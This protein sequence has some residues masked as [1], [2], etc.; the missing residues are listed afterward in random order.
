MPESVQLPTNLSQAAESSFEIVLASYLE[1]TEKGLA[2][3]I[4]TW[5]NRYPQWSKELRA[6]FD[7]AAT[8]QTVTQHLPSHQ[9]PQVGHQL[10]PYQLLEVI[11]QGGMGI[12]WKARHMRLDRI[13][14][15]KLLG[16]QTGWQQRDWQRFQNE[17]QAVSSLD[18]PHIVPVFDYGEYQGQQ[19]LAMKLVTG[20]TLSDAAI[21]SNSADESNRG[22]QTDPVVRHRRIARI[23]YQVAQAIH[24][25][26]QRGVLHRDLKPTN[27][28]ID[29]QDCPF[30]V[31]F[32]LAKQL[33]AAMNLT[34]T[35]T[36]LGTPSYMAPEAVL[37]TIESEVD[38]PEIAIS[39]A[40]GQGGLRTN[41]TTYTTAVDV[42]GL[43]ATLYFLLTGQAPVRSRTFAAALI[44]IRDEEP[45]SVRV[46][47]PSVDRNLAAIC[48]HALAKQPVARYESADRLAQDLLNW[49]EGRSITAREA[50]LLARAWLWSK[51]NKVWATALSLA[52][53]GLIFGMGALVWGLRATTVARDEALRQHEQALK[54]LLT[55]WEDI[56]DLENLRPDL[57]D[58]RLE[59]L[60]RIQTQLSPM[61]NDP[62]QGTRASETNF[63]LEADM[64]DLCEYGVDSQRSQQ[65]FERAM[66]IAQQLQQQSGGKHWREVSFAM[67]HLA[68]GAAM[69]GKL[70]VACNYLQECLV[71]RAERLGREPSLQ[72][73]ADLAQTHLRL[74]WYLFRRFDIENSPDFAREGAR[75]AAIA[76]KEY[77][78]LVLA[79]PHEIWHARY[80]CM[81]Y[82]Y[83]GENNR[84]LGNWDKAFSGLRTGLAY[85]VQ[86]K[87]QLP[88]YAAIL[89]LQEVYLLQVQ[90]S[91]CW[92]SG[93][94]DEGMAAAE[95]SLAILHRL[96]AFSPRAVNLFSV[97]IM[98]YE[99]LGKNQQGAGQTT[100]AEA[101]L[102]SG[103]Q[104]RER[105]ADQENL[106][107]NMTIKLNGCRESWRQAA[108]ADPI[109]DTEVQGSL[110]AQS[111]QL[112]E[113]A[114]EEKSEAAAIQAI[115]MGMTQIEL[116]LLAGQ[117]E[118]AQQI[119]DELQTLIANHFPELPAHQQ[120][121]YRQFTVHG[122]LI[123]IPESA[124]VGQ[125]IA[126]CSTAP[127]VLHRLQL[128]AHT[129]NDWDLLAAT[130]LKLKVIATNFRLKWLAV[131]GLAQVRQALAVQG[132]PF[133]HGEPLSELVEE[134]SAFGPH[135]QLR[136]Q[137]ELAL[138]P[139]D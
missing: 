62:I 104:I 39:H 101:S 99:L 131:K 89:D 124:Q 37:G 82:E 29:E 33:D 139:G 24:H 54:N 109:Y 111:Q 44:E 85:V 26:H 9:I 16:P 88:Q 84:C 108:M 134:L 45:Q 8:L 118:L 112:R 23:M 43:G 126:S 100:N 2:G 20:Y 61:L 110:Q 17:A 96:T 67:S 14:A 65:H 123:R 31:D 48:H 11:G 136:L 53:A 122:D 117:S 5:L 3:E 25:A 97:M 86:A 41:K 114:I 128:L 102:R 94:F 10:G 7:A 42:Y 66:E 38:N 40:D 107:A 135:A 59:L 64:G 6:Y 1:A 49:L 56:K 129:S 106:T 133:A 13:V 68:D 116:Y 103:W 79:E 130:S 132:V 46:L 52:L 30:V 15:L 18:H 95:Q 83:I 98:S 80:L 55:V 125:A 32:G 87:T 70:D 91:A 113:T 50:T 57:D 93:R 36:F 77:R 76:E 21:Q 51:R 28:L 73:R 63:W 119:F 22:D 138:S 19:Y 60:Q 74:A 78:Q 35:G 47:N 34:H 120:G 71:I 75:H 69:Q 81:C 92:W 137:A 105:F 27:I 121:L 127:G 90:A 72:A 4:E 12:V 115:Q 58:L